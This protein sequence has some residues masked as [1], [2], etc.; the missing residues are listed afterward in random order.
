MV[1]NYG[2]FIRK[3]SGIFSRRL[4]AIMMLAVLLCSAYW[5]N[6]E[7]A[8][9]ATFNPD[10]YADYVLMSE[11]EA[12]R[13]YNNYIETMT[14][15]G[16]DLKI[17]CKAEVNDELK[18]KNYSVYFDSYMK[19]AYQAANE[20]ML[21]HSSVDG[22]STYYRY[23]CTVREVHSSMTANEYS[24]AMNKARTIAANNNY[25]SDYDK[26]KRVYKW[27]CDNVEYD[28]SYSDGSIYDALIGRK[29]VCAGYAGAFQVI[30][31]A[32]GIECYINEGKA[33]GEDHA[34][35]IVKLEGKYYFV[36]ATWGDTSTE[37]DKYLL[38]GTDMR[39]NIT[40][41]TVS[42]SSYKSTENPEE[43]TAASGNVSETQAAAKPV[44]KETIVAKPTEAAT[45]GNGNMGNIE[46]AE[47]NN[48][49]TGEIAGENKEQEDKA[50]EN[51]DLPKES[52]ASDGL[53]EN[54]SAFAGNTIE[55]NTINSV[56]KITS[57]SEEEGKGQD[58]GS[59]TVII[60]VFGVIFLAGGIFL[61]IKFLRK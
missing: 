37:Y 27:I 48:E 10:D 49:T 38:F 43:T 18:Y 42:S 35:N 23:Y 28:Y 7:A 11:S 16:A 57:V 1:R 8:G 19:F 39:T 12:I 9:A 3:C 2:G 46:V 24:Q 4:T 36:D 59:V 6:G 55:N 61:Y 51:Q 44:E 58:I 53:T 26:I 30:M 45:S 32:L 20:I 50:Q 60:S 40:G 52:G 13:A 22:Y 25:G 56:E 21:V 17:Y 15:E 5:L 47:N 33:N 31:D 41:L 54:T 29:S 14:P 34:W